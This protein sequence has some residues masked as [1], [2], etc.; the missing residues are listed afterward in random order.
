MYVRLAFAVAAHLEP[1]ILIVDEVL[2]V[3]DAQFQK[4]C[5]GK[6]QDVARGEGRTVLFVSHNMAAVETLCRR[7]IFLQQGLL[8]F[9]GETRQAITGYMSSFERPVRLDLD[10]ETDRSGSGM[11]R[12]RNV[13]LLSEGVNATETVSGASVQ[14][15]FTYSNPQNVKSA[16]FTFT[17]Y[18]ENGVAVTSIN[19]LMLG[20]KMALA[21]ASGVVTCSVPR[22]TLNQGRYRVAAAIQD[23]SGESYDHVPSALWF[24]V[25]GCKFYA[26]GKSPDPRYSLVL[27]D[28]SWS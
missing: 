19:S 12:L 1:E 4:K 6:M 22:L 23:E 20:K 28:H 14:F 25:T 7:G 9:D 2:A 8:A 13:T 26:S 27:T 18:A 17:I 10:E 16:Q 11:V 5:L 3:G 21:P 15:E 24:Q